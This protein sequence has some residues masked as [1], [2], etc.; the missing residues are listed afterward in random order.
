MDAKAEPKTRLLTEI[1]KL[2]N[3][4]QR[5]KTAERKY[6]L[7]E[8]AY[9]EH[10]GNYQDVI[11]IL[12]NVHDLIQVV[13]RD[14]R[15]LFVNRAWRETLGYAREDIETLTLFEML[16]EEYRPYFFQAFELAA[17]GETVENVEVVFAAKDG[18]RVAAAGKLYSKRAKEN[19]LSI[20]AIFRTISPCE[21]LKDAQEKRIGAMLEAASTSVLRKEEVSQ[22]KK[23]RHG[24]TL[25]SIADAVITTDLEGT[26]TFMNHTAMALTGWEHDEGVRRRIVFKGVDGRIASYPSE[27]NSPTLSE[28]V[29]IHLTEPPLLISRDGIEIPVEY[30]NAQIEDAKGNI[31]GHVLVLH[32]ITER[33]WEVDSLRKIRDEFAMRVD[34]RTAEHAEAIEKLRILKEAVDTMRIGVTI[35][36]TNGTILHTNPADAKMHGY[37]VE[38]LL[39][40]DVRSFAPSERRNPMTVEQIEEMQGRV[41]ESV[42]IRKDNSKFPVWLMSSVVKDGAGNT[43]AIVTS[44]EDISERKLVEKALSEERN[45]LRLSLDSLPEYIFVKDLE[46]RFLMNNMAHVRFLGAATRSELIGKGSADFFSEEFTAQDEAEDRNVLQTGRPLLDRKHD[47][48]NQEGQRRL[49]STSKIPLR[50]AQGELVGLMNISRDIV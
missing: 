30:S 21:Q 1:K 32:D 27:P 7:A 37:S 25:N 28:D 26:V 50:N 22:E 24:V 13:T 20:R 17:S 45:L 23:Q 12:E 18:K 34:E 35:T 43:L 6:T 29:A 19:S 48:I 40:K 38:E 16:D 33:Q 3:Q 44:C 11:D 5:Y 31:S 47:I 9:R 14:G 36:N 49:H 39:G 15:F 8:E 42:N 46:G 41:R 4:I 10:E 2:R